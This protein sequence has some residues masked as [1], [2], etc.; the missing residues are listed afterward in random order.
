MTSTSQAELAWAEPIIVD[1]LRRFGHQPMTISDM[2]RLAPVLGQQSA[3]GLSRLL[4]G[5]VIRG[6]IRRHAPAEGRK[7]MRY[8]LPPAVEMP[9]ST[10]PD[11]K[12]PE[13][14]PDLRMQQ[15]IERCRGTQ[16]ISINAK[17]GQS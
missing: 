3:Q 1:L 17:G 15:A 13:W 7:Q 14:K 4:M 10:L 2:A 16:F 8:D 9:K 12:R 5:M 11:W 6:V